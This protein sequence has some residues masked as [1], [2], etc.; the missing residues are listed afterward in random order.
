MQQQSRTDALTKLF[1][2]RY[3]D[4]RATFEF[5]RAQRFRQPFSLLVI[6]IDHFKAFNDTHGHSRG[7]EVL[8]TVARQLRE[9]V[10][11][12]DSVCRYGGEEFAVILPSTSGDEAM[13]VAE[14][15][16]QAI[17]QGKGQAPGPITI[18]IGVASLGDS[19]FADVGA[20]FRAADAALYEAK[21]AG[22]NRAV[23]HRVKTPAEPVAA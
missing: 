2:R 18:S 4:E 10:R 17:E 19:E 23:R 1:N 20:L 15:L 14:S 21:S 8:R 13:L 11:D 22:R 16:R 9:G 5:E 3:F 12:Q 6:D 7:D